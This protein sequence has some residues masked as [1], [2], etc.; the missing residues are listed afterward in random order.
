M[1]PSQSLSESSHSH[2]H[3][4]VELGPGV[5]RSRCIVA[6]IVNLI[7]DVIRL[8]TLGSLVGTF[9]DRANQWNLRR[10]VTNLTDNQR[11]YSADDR[12]RIKDAL[13]ISGAGFGFRL[14][15]VA[16]RGYV[17]S[18]QRSGESRIPD[19]VA[20]HNDPNEATRVD[21]KILAGFESTSFWQRGRPEIGGSVSASDLDAYLADVAA[22][23]IHVRHQWNPRVQAYTDPKYG[24]YTAALVDEAWQVIET[25]T[26]GPRRAVGIPD[27]SRPSLH[28]NHALASS[29]EPRSV[30]CSPRRRPAV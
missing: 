9:R 6:S 18:S 21:L 22:G 26:P 28:A 27:A 4:H 20:W 5:G 7:W 2:R 13:G 16:Y 10:Y 24:P 30:R 29:L 15:F 14:R 17:T 3:L 8:V 19:L 12:T 25:C 23:E 11:G 1:W